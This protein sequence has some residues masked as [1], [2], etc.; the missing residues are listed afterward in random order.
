M[1]DLKYKVGDK[2]RIKSLDWYNENADDLGNIDCNGTYFLRQQSDFCGRI[3]TIINA[4]V[5]NGN[6]I[7]GMNEDQDYYFWTDEMIECKEEE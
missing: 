3:M 6:E 2:V 4:D 7:Y 1:G 5:I